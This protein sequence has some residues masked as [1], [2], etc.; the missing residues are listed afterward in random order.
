MKKLIIILF[1]IISL[2]EFIAFNQILSLVSQKNDIAVLVG[3][4]CISIFI[5]INYL[6]FNFIKKQFK[7]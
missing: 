1:P 7:K 6:L 4:T 2:I 5:F 3:V